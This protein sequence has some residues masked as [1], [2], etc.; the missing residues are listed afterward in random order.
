MCLFK[1]NP[2]VKVLRQTAQVC[3]GL[4]LEL[5]LSVAWLLLVLLLLL[6]LLFALLFLLPWPRDCLF[7]VHILADGYCRCILFSGV[8][9][10]VFIVLEDI[11]TG[12]AEWV[13]KRGWCDIVEDEAMTAFNEFAELAIPSI[14][15]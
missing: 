4:P 1:V 14:C 3:L 15:R 5:V 13:V 11:E 2:C 8:A 9:L 10:V 6:L 12:P 7:V